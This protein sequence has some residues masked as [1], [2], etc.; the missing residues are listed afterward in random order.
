MIYC[1]HTKYTEYL[2]QCFA[3]EL[4]MAYVPTHSSCFK[5]K[6]WKQTNP[7]VRQIIQC[8]SAYFPPECCWCVRTSASTLLNVCACIRRLAEHTSRPHCPWHYLSPRDRPCPGL[9]EAMALRSQTCLVEKTGSLSTHRAEG[10]RFACLGYL[11]HWRSI[12]SRS[13]W[14][15]QAH[16]WVTLI[17]GKHRQDT[18]T[19]ILQRYVTYI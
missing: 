4:T 15:T 19:N 2:Y 12:P 18:G 13:R 9:P 14:L 5:F 1:R 7:S 6:L 10:P 11:L 16:S 8:V 17:G 3:K